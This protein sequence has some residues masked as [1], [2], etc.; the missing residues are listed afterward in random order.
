[1]KNYLLKV[2]AVFVISL[3]FLGGANAQNKK[4]V[5]LYDP[6][7]ATDTSTMM[8]PEMI[9]A[10]FI[11]SLG[12]DVHM[13]GVPNIFNM[14]QVQR[15]SLRDADLIVIG[16]GNASANFNA[17]Q[18][19]L[20]NPITT[21]VLSLSM[22]AISAAKM[23]WFDG[24]EDYGGVADVIKVKVNFPADP[25]FAGLTMPG[26]SLAFWNGRWNSLKLNSKVN[27]GNGKLMAT[28]NSSDP[29][30]SLLRVAY[31]RFSPDVEFYAISGEPLKYTD[32]IPR[33]YRTFIG[34]GADVSAGNPYNY[35]GYTFDGQD[36][37]QKEIE[38]LLA[39]ASSVN[40]NA[41]V[42]AA[43]YPNPAVNY[44]TVE[45]DN[46]NEVRILD[47]T[48]KLIL[49]KV[50][51]GNE[52]SVNIRDLKAGVYIVYAIDSYN[53]TAVQKFIKK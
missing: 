39:F 30:D 23:K 46:L 21:P 49:S 10:N 36:V 18:D 9:I 44:L 2:S 28:F 13:L 42:S 43:V 53:N 1:M 24:T 47:I 34:M 37:L 31:A 14:N 35:F 29:V 50:T 8:H 4:V 32:H 6:G 48:G 25:V 19:S 27:N 12:C 11:T 16:R 41:L 7:K 15:D 22:F 3:L 40:E 33:G 38:R 17:K 20:W 52:L 5:Y 26:D 45:M 51:N